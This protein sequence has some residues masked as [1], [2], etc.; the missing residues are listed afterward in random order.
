MTLKEYLA[1][2]GLTQYRFAKNIGVDRQT[3]YR[4]AAG[5]RLPRP[6]LM[7]LIYRGTGGAVQPNDFY[8]LDAAE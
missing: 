5:E 2:H 3:V 7:A 4:W 6:E 1:E 8:N